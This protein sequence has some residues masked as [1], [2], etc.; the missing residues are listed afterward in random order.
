MDYI[1]TVPRAEELVDRAFRQ[2]AKIE[3]RPKSARRDTQA[4]IDSAISYIESRLSKVVKTF[5]T[6]EQLHPFYRELFD[7]MFGID[8][9]RK[10]LG[11]VQWAHDGIHRLRSTSS[12]RLSAGED[13]DR[14]RRM[15]Y[16][17]TVSIIDD[18]ADDLLRLDEIRRKMKKAPVIDPDAPILV[19]CG[20]PNVGKSTLMRRISTGEPEVA[21]YPFTTK[22]IHIGHLELPTFRLQVIDTPGLFDRPVEEMNL[23][24]RQGIAALRHIADAGI[25][26]M[27]PTEMCGYLWEKQVHLLDLLREWFT[28]PLLILENKADSD[29]FV[30]RL[31][32]SVPLSADL[33]SEGEI[34]ALVDRIV[35]LVPAP[36]MPEWMPPKDL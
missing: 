30:Q 10:R 11:A 8:N 19:I 24:E 27:D 36:P 23:I 20:Y 18:I 31:E 33:A 17:R 28:I 29:L 3:V 34:A 9:V 7:L 5:P 1:P 21:H 12:R 15:V 13:P 26:V 2:A 4:K 25:V 16:G 32:G 22:E 14:V 6:F 35:G